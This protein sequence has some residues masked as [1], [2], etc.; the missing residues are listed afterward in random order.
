MEKF[1]TDHARSKSQRLGS[2][3]QEK[4]SARLEFPRK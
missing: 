1:E 3:F 2:H 4:L